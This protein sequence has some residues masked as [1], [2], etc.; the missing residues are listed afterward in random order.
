[1]AAE[2]FARGA[3]AQACGARLFCVA[4]VELLRPLSSACSR[5]RAVDM[6]CSLLWAYFLVPAPFRA[7]QGVDLGYLAMCV[8]MNALCRCVCDGRR[9]AVKSRDRSFTDLR[10][11]RLFLMVLAASLPAAVCLARSEPR[12]PFLPFSAEFS[13]DRQYL[14][15]LVRSGSAKIVKPALDGSNLWFGARRSDDAWDALRAALALTEV[16]QGADA[17]QYRNLAA[18]WVRDAAQWL[19]QHKAE[20]LSKISA[21]GRTDPGNEL[22]RDAAYLLSLDYYLNGRQDS[23]RLAA[24]VLLRLSEVFPNWPFVQQD[25]K[26]YQQSDTDYYKRW[27]AAGLWNW[28]YYLDFSKSM[29]VARAYDLLADS[30]VFPSAWAKQVRKRL[31]EHQVEVLMRWSPCYSNMDG[32]LIKGLLAYGI[33][34]GRR[35]WFETGLNWYDALLRVGFYADGF[36]HEGSP[37]YHRDLQRILCRYIPWLVQVR[38][39]GE[40]WL[41]DGALKGLLGVDLSQKHSEQHRRI[42]VALQKMV[43][44]DKT[45]LAVHDSDYGLK[46]YLEDRPGF[47]GSRLLGCLGH[48]VLVAGTTDDPVEAHLHYGGTHGHEHYD[49]LNMVLF[50]SGREMLSETTY[51]PVSEAECPREWVRSTAGHNTVVVDGLDQNS[52]FEGNK[53]TFTQIDE[54]PGVGLLWRYRDMGHGN[55]L[56]DGK[57][58]LF[59]T[60]D[61]QVQVVEAEGVR[62]YSQKVSLSSYRRM[63]VLV[64][65][66]N[67]KFYV[68]DVFRV[69]GG[70][71]HDWMLHGPLQEQYQVFCNIAGSSSSVKLG[72]YLEARSVVDGSKVRF[73]GFHCPDG[74]E[75]IS[76]LLGAEGSKVYFAE[77]PAM[78][79]TGNA[80]FIDWRREGGQ[81]VFVAV[82][83]ASRSQSRIVRSA[84]LVQPAGVDSVVAVSL[85]LADG[86]QDLV[87]AGTGPNSAVNMTWNG[88]QVSF[89]GHFGYARLAG[90]QVAKLAL[91]DG[92]GLQVGDRTIQQPEASVGGQVRGVLRREQGAS[93]NG[94]VVSASDEAGRAKAGAVL[95]IDYDDEVRQAFLI[96]QV[97]RDGDVVRLI[98]DEDPGFEQTD[99]GCRMTHYPNWGFRQMPKW[100]VICSTVWQQASGG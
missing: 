58:L 49:C 19:L 64:D 2:S 23:G 47:L 12:R 53:R 52:R 54:V 48:A 20:L 24:T 67:G 46:V 96:R 86:R 39:A 38:T 36:W 77:G 74:S 51:R 90:G 61:G 63:L 44:P 22:A 17:E 85:E 16:C 83:E 79:R 73:I 37:A 69:A 60:L 100:R 91:S 35:D 72:K 40:Q 42:M 65:C 4:T 25:G 29:P 88:M 34:F 95:L 89:V 8:N 56:N 21:N 11:A 57:L 43:L 93:S 30:G 80:W 27:D 55:T 98:I 97:E 92:Q 10:V 99:F 78:R 81:S 26:T 28:W 32:H 76:W 18:G 62:A 33:I 41:A 7:M 50:A 45:Y 9:L 94:I 70:N 59:D 5:S 14:E 82:H 1:V 71:R 87:L 84:Q 66:G 13:G 75:V 6:L 15:G 31:F 3:C 68:V